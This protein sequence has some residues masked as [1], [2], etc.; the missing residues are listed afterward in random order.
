MV[1]AAEA[2]PRTLSVGFGAYFLLLLVFAYLFAPR[3]F[4]PVDP[5]TTSWILATYMLLGAVALVGIGAGAA[6]RGA[7]LDDRVDEL[8]ADARR[9][10]REAA[11]GRDPWAHPRQERVV[12]SGSAEREVELLLDSLD[13]LGET[14]SAGRSAARSLEAFL[15]TDAAEF[16]RRL[17]AD[18]W[19]VA[20]LRRVRA[21]VALTLTGP[22]MAAVAIVGAFAPL[23]PAG[24][25]MLLSDLWLKAFLELVGLGGLVGVAAYAGAGFRQLR[26]RAR[27]APRP[28]LTPGGYPRG[29]A[30]A[31]PRGRTSARR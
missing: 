12:D 23:L 27:P 31:S 5:G 25:G 9:L 19:E 28:A 10:R 14:A 24:D 29:Q 2:R 17:A 7:R 18:A 16:E 26:R 6:R 8:E 30:V 20:R 13:P 22:A 11:M 4:P 21:A 15:E 1:K 3:V